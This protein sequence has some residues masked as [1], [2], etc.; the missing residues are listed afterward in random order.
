MNDCILIIS[1]SVGDASPASSSSGNA[2]TAEEK[3]H[4][5]HE[6]H[7]INILLIEDIPYQTLPDLTRGYVDGRL[8]VGGCIRIEY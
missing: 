3:K 4:E 2:G 1:Q 6:K 7:E 8:D 5:K